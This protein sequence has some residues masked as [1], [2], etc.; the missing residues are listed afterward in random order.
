[1]TCLSDLVLLLILLEHPLL[2]GRF[3]AV[4]TVNLVPNYRANCPEIGEILQQIRRNISDSLGELFSTS[5]PECGNGLWYRLAYLNMTDPSQ[6]CSPAWREYNT[7][8]VRACGRP[9][10]SSEV[11]LQ[12]FIVS[13]DSTVG[14]VEE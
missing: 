9:V 5:V 14:C 12:L 2:H 7:S 10:S 6:Q 1:M 11:V 13:T 8:G 4:P 3:L